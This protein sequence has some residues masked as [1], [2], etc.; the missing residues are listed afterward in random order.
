M[1]I[2]LEAA[3]LDLGTALRPSA[4][5]QNGQKRFLLKSSVNVMVSPSWLGSATVGT[6]LRVIIQ[7]VMY[8]FSS[9]I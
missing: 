5:Q 9:V 1:Q 7:I 4:S 2:M 8:A 3:R 6:L